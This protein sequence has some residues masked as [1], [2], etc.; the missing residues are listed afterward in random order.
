MLNRKNG[1]TTGEDWIEG[2]GY[3]GLEWEDLVFCLYH[4]D[5]NRFNHK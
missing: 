3:H 1:D 5:T 2:H 4:K